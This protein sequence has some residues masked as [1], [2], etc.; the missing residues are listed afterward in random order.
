MKITLNTIKIRDLVDGYQ[1]NDEAG[2]VGYGGR[3]DIRPPYQ[4]EFCYDDN[5]QQAV[6]DTVENGFPLNTMYWVVR[7]DGR[8][9]VLDGQQRTI[10]ICRYVNGS[11]SHNMRYFTNLQPDEK[12]NILNYDL[13]VYFCEGSESE[14]LS[15]FKTI[16]IAG[17]RLTNQEIRNAVFAGSWTAEAKKIFS[18]SNCAGKLL[19]DKYVN[20]NPIRQELL[21]TALGWFVGKDDK[22]IC[23]Y[24]GQHQNDAN[25]NELWVY[26]QFVIAWVKAMFIVYRKEM[27]GID[28][29]SLY[30]QYHENSYDPAQLEDEICSLIENDEVTNHKGIY[31]YLFDRKESHLS[32]REFDEKMKRKAYEQ[33]G[34][35]CPLCKKHF[36][37][38]EM[39]GDHII[40]WS[41]G[42]K[43]VM[44][45]LQMLCRLCNNTKSDR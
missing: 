15:W 43:T 24:M 38:S 30:N 8:Y 1:D 21:E 29:G 3:L 36:E 10:S 12:E 37:F 14:K 44:E 4:R 23:K 41:K 2:V 22:L 26:F 25:A 16:N 40:P 34:G 19:S 35:I 33:Q 28:W 42:G 18:K 39:E 45:N 31:Y 6:M 9:E 5:Q 7:D 20:A 13:Q 27:K 17:E 11:F 32:L